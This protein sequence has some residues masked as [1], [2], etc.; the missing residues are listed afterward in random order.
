MENIA[1]AD[2]FLSGHDH[3]KWVAMKTR[4]AL[5]SSGVDVGLNQRKILFCRTG[6]FLK[7][8]E[9]DEPSYVAAGGLTPTDLGVVKIELTPKRKTKK[10]P[11]VRHDTFYVDIHASI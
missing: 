8:Y 5:S 4:L 7:G 1:E 11:G 3:K 10:E 6:S 2:I 9:P